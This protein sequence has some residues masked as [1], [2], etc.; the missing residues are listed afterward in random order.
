MY[1][2]FMN[3]K[4]FLQDSDVRLHILSLFGLS[5]MVIFASNSLFYQELYSG[6]ARTMLLSLIAF[7]ALALVLIRRLFQ[8]A[9]QV[10]SA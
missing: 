1:V 5:V 7:V 6:R 2:L 9:Q 8:V 4:E 3:F 10:H